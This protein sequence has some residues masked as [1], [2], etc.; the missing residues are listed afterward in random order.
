ME[1]IF[2]LAQQMASQIPDSEKKKLQ[3]MDMNEMVS[4]I[5]N[6]VLKTVQNQNQPE[7]KK[8]ESKKK[9]Q[10]KEESED[11]DEINERSEDLHYNLNVKLE[12]LYR[13]KEKK[14]SYKRKRFEVVKDSK[15]RRTHKLV[16]EKKKIVINILPGTV[17]GHKIYFRGEADH[18]PGKEAGDVIIT[19]CEEEHETFDREGDNLVVLKNISISEIYSLEYSF[20]HM[21]GREVVV[22]SVDNDVLHTFDGVRKIVGEG[23][24]IFDE[25][26]PDTPVH[27]DL[28]VRFNLVLPE[29]LTTEQIEI[30]KQ[31]N[32]PINKNTS[33]STDNVK[34]LEQVTEED[35]SKLDHDSEY[36]EDDDEEEDDDD[37]DEDDDDEEDDEDDDDDEQEDTLEITGEDSD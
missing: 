1:D 29:K 24:P 34:F 32:H 18:F 17:D 11:S 23:M 37:D 19:I 6:N 21:D 3:G 14:L 5:F 2:A 27:G 26:N 20:T 8:I 16:E 33:D 15:G 31:I 28:F 10:I 7:T 25:T 12:D 22:K 13:G 30:L 35:I 4:S 9:H 36:S